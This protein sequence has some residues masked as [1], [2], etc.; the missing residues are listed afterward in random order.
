[1]TK[2]F[3]PFAKT[4]PSN[5]QSSP[6]KSPPRI[7]FYPGESD[8]EFT[9]DS[10]SENTSQSN[11]QSDFRTNE[12]FSTPPK[13]SSIELD[14]EEKTHLSNL[15]DSHPDMSTSQVYAHIQALRLKR[16]CKDG[17]ED[18]AEELAMDPVL[19]RMNSYE[20][21][22]PLAIAVFNNQIKTVRALL[23]RDNVD[24]AACNCVLI[25]TACSN[26]HEEIL[27]LLMMHERVDMLHRSLNITDLFRFGYSPVVREILTN[28]RIP[29][30]VLVETQEEREERL[31]RLGQKTINDC[32][33]INGQENV[34]KERRDLEEL[35]ERIMSAIR[36]S[37]RSDIV[38]MLSEDV[39][40]KIEDRASSKIVEP[41][42]IKQRVKFARSFMRFVKSLRRIV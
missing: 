28:G 35:D 8:G 39:V 16:A 38:N 10:T 29:S 19:Q 13:A 18:A 25:K 3:F 34:E 31:A 32:L 26:K 6:I 7:G 30:E 37:Y 41:P 17:L 27:H 4:K 12:S 14:E 36:E 11:S 42:K 21:M 9:S 40:R 20:L 24:P 15:R 23:Q 33:R 1:M 5:E 2:I 22:G